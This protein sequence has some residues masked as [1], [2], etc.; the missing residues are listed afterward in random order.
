LFVLLFLK[1]NLI[2]LINAISVS[3]FDIL[4][5]ITEKTTDRPAADDINHKT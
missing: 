5:A 3:P 2:I 1:I 4:L